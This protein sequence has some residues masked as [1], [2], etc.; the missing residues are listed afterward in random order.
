MK[1]SFICV[2][3]VGG[4]DVASPYRK[5]QRRLGDVKLHKTPGV[6]VAV[7]VVVVVVVAS[8]RTV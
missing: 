5:S 8:E 3:A 1:N 7:V 6:V 2:I 4:V